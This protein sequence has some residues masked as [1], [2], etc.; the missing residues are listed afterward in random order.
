MITEL[1]LQNPWWDASERINSDIHLQKIENLPFRYYPTLVDSQDLAC[2][3]VITLRG[4]RQVGKTT[5]LK[6]LID[7]LIKS[8]V[9]PINILYYNAELLGSERELFNLLQEYIGLASGKKFILFD[10]VTT[11]PRWEYGIKHI[12]DIGLGENT[13]FLLTGSSAVD[14]RRGAERLPGRRGISK[15]DRV[16]LP[17]SFRQYCHLRGFDKMQHLDTQNW[18][19]SLVKFFPE[20]K[21]NFSRIQ[22]YFFD[23]L[24]H[25]GFLMAITDYLNQKSVAST[26]METYK[27]VVISDFEKLRK[28]RI[29][30][31]NICRRILANL[32]T[33]VSWNGLASDAG[34]IAVMTAKDYVYLLSDSYLIYILEFLRRGYQEPSPN[35]NRKL[36]PFDPLIYRV[37]ADIAGTRLENHT[38]PKI[39]EGIVGS[40]LLRM[41]EIDKHSGFS[42]LMNTFYWRSI[43][44]KEVDFVSIWN[45]KEIP[46][47]VKYQSRISASDYTTIKRSFGKGIILTKDTFFID[48]EIIGVPVSCFLYL[49]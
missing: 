29:I 5:F 40:S 17:Q 45:G 43:R 49:I 9:P 46:I 11:V 8:G 42:L 37:L 44:G 48:G 35:K 25:G 26:T 10:E 38:Y 13:L 16:L 32:S 7:R 34:S 27:T 6:M 30:L 41:N 36:V 28:D 23:F 22:A 14:L 20:I 33:P 31:R 12:I 15:P 24:I 2:S 18:H 39:I 47:E 19:S 21:I 4:P 1:S 3:G